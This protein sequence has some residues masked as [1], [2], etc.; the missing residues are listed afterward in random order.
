MHRETILTLDE[1]LAAFLDHWEIERVKLL[2]KYQLRNEHYKK[3]G[4]LNIYHAKKVNHYIHE[5]RMLREL[6]RRA[7][8][9]T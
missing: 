7:A 4:M 2:K 5:L 6:R 9:K 1:Q 3:S 8:I